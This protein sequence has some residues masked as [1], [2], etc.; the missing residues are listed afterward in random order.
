MGSRLAGIESL[1]RAGVEGRSPRPR[2]PGRRV[3]VAQKPG[4]NRCAPKPGKGQGCVRTGQDAGVAVEQAEHRRL[5]GRRKAVGFERVRAHPLV[6]E[7]PTVEEGQGVAVALECR[8]LPGTAFAQ[9]PEARLAEHPRQTGQHV[10]VVVAG[11]RHGVDARRGQ[12]QDAG[13]QRSQGLV[14]AVLAIDHVAGEHHCLDFAVEGQLDD[15]LPGP[16]GGEAAIAGQRCR[17]PRRP[18]AE[19]EI[20]GD[21]ELEGHLPWQW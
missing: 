3:D 12:A 9:H 19:M 2:E 7:G 11:H 10:E 15:P 13:R 21:E 5:G 18:A 16:G 6:R 1:G 14:I 20:A 8:A 17:Q 4:R